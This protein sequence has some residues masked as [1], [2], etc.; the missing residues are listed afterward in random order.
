MMRSRN[1]AVGGCL[2]G[3]LLA[4]L[5]G[6]FACGQTFDTPSENVRSTA[7]ALTT[8][9]VDPVPYGAGFSVSWSGLTNPTST[10]WIGVWPSS[11]IVGPSTLTAFRWTRATTSGTATFSPIAAGTYFAQAFHNNTYTPKAGE[12]AVQF[13]VSGGTQGTLDAPA[14]YEPGTSFQVNFAGV[15]ARATNWVGVYAQGAG[16]S[17]WLTW[18]YAPNATSGTVTFPDLPVTSGGTYEVR[19]FGDNTATAITTSDT[20]TVGTPADNGSSLSVPGNLT[21]ANSVPVTFGGFTANASNWIAISTPGAPA[22]TYSAWMYTPNASSGTVTF[23]PLAAGNYVARAFF[24]WAGTGSYVVR[25]ETAFTI[26]TPGLPARLAGLVNNVIQTVAVSSPGSVL[27][28]ASITGLATDELA[29]AIDRGP[30]G[31]LYLLAATEGIPTPPS[32]GHL[33]TLNPVTGAAT[34]VGTTAF[35]FGPFPGT[36]YDLE[37]D[38]TLM[39]ARVVRDGMN[40]W[41]TSSLSAGFTVSP[42]LMMTSEIYGIAHDATMLYGL[43]RND[44]QLYTI[45]FMG[46]GTAVGPLGFTPFNHM[47]FDIAGGVGYAAVEQIGVS[48]YHLWTINLTTGAGTDMGAIANSARGMAYLPSDN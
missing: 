26:G 44:T 12:A 37:I 22:R 15:G 33:Y 1:Q 17:S 9:S 23:P 29:R 13:T 45:N 24:D 40:Q 8:I 11:Q 2:R 25:N 38:P 20:F 47:A 32:T 18:M 42:S 27:T 28:S 21:T 41:V 35:D 39:I 4:V 34:M 48:G 19:M 10:D 6:V 30:D 14:T 31:M 5:A 36:S 46:Q 3:G 43:R 7:S 16:D